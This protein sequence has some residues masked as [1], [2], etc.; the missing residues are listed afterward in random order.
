MRHFHSVVRNDSTFL[1]SKFEMMYS[2]STRDR[3][4]GALLA[5][6]ESSSDQSLW[7]PNEER[8]M[9]SYW[10]WLSQLDD[11]PENRYAPSFVYHNLNQGYSLVI[12]VYEQEYDQIVYPS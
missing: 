3:V 10:E 12:V 1:V 5:C 4:Q 2:P 8:V 9:F 11:S 6:L 7:T